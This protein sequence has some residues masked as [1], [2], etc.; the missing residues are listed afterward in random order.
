MALYKFNLFLFFINVFTYHAA[1]TAF[2]SLKLKELHLGQKPLPLDW[3]IEGINIAANLGLI[4]VGIYYGINFSVEGGIIAGV[5]GLGGLR[6]SY[7]NIKRLRGKIIYKNY[8]LMSHI[9][10]MLGSYIGA[11][12]AFIVNNNRWMHLPEIVAWLGPTLLLVPLMIREI[13]VFKKIKL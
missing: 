10:G 11:I 12:T 3:T 5:F 9:G 13:N 1:I 7:V 6:N 4:A 2:R 8:W